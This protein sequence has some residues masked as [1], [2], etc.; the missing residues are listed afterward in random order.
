M[1][2]QKTSLQQFLLNTT[3][4]LLKSNFSS[5]SLNPMVLHA[6]IILLL[7]AVGSLTEGDDI[8]E[9]QL[10][11]IKFAK[12]TPKKNLQWTNHPYI[13]LTVQL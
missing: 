2:R 5:S 4:H 8:T 12:L 6:V 13:C 3:V 7:F 1:S 10:S 11:P 9:L